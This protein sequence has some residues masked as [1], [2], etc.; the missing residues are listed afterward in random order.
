MTTYTVNQPG[1]K[2]TAFPSSLKRGDIMV[3]NNT[4]S[5]MTGTILEWKV[6][7][8]GLYTIEAWGAQGGASG[9]SGARM[10]GDFDLK[11]GQVVRLLVGQAGESSNSSVGNN[12]GGGGGSFVVAGSLILAAGGGGGTSQYGGNSKY[13]LNGET[14]TTTAGSIGVSLG[15]RAGGCTGAG[16]GGGYNGSGGN[17]GTDCGSTIYGYGG[18]G[19]GSGSTGGIGYNGG[20]GGFG[21]GGGSGFSAGGGGGGYSGGI[22][23]ANGGSTPGGGGGSY[24]SGANQSNSSGVRSGHGL[25]QITFIG[26]ANEPPTSPLLT[27]Q[28][29]SNSMNLSNESILLEWSASTDPEGNPITYEIDFYNGS[30]WINIASKIIDT[31]HVCMLPSCDTD[32]AQFRI[33]AIDDESNAS[34]YTMSN[35]FTVAKQVYI[36]KDGEINKSYKD[37]AWQLL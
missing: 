18:K 32:K 33:R 13:G 5:G 14:G 2:T 26:S 17:S 9:G 24:N 27:K 35:V 36:V 10:R 30:T 23:G 16:G 3:F 4:S 22:G 31:N 19:Y 34:Q 8:A 25:I 28:P 15:G 20:P 11:V 6:P 21:G 12:G 7:L 1:N 29:I 37:G